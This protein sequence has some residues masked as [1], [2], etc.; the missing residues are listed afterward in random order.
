MKSQIKLALAVLVV[1]A[2]GVASLAE[3]APRHPHSRNSGGG[4]I[5]ERSVPSYQYQ[6]AYRTSQPSYVVRNAAAA[7]TVVYRTVVVPQAPAVATQVVVPV[8]R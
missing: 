7:P 6:S 3:A 2:F 4:G 5:F 1:S 8:K